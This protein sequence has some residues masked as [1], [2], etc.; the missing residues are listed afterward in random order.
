MKRSFA[1]IAATVIL[2][3]GM[4]GQAGSLG[5]VP[6]IIAKY[7]RSFIERSGAQTFGEMLDTG[8]LRYFFTGGR[9]LLVMVNGQPY[10]TTASNLDAIVLSAVER[11][12]VIRAESLGTIGGSAAVRGAFNLVLRD[13]LEGFDVRAVVRKPSRDGGESGQG[14][15]VWGEKLDAGGYITVGIDIFDRSEIEGSTRDHSRSEWTSEG[16][17][18]GSKNV[19]VGGNTAYFFDNG[20]RSSPVGGCDKAHGYTGELSNPPGITTGDK[21]C[22]FAYG[23]FW[24]DT[25]SYEQKN[26][27]INLSNP[28]GEHTE[29]EMYANFTQGKRKF[30]YA[31]SVGT[32]VLYE[33]IPKKLVNSINC[34]LGGNLGC[35]PDDPPEL[36][37]GPV[38]ENTPIALSHRFTGHGNRDWITDRDEYDIS[39]G[40]NHRIAPNIAFD[41]KFNVYRGISDIDGNTFVSIPDIVAEVTDGR[42]DVVNPLSTMPS[43]RAAVKASS[44]Q[45]DERAVSKY[46]DARFAFDGTIPG[47]GGRD[48]AWTAG[49]QFSKVDSSLQLR[50]IKDNGEIIDDVTE[51]LGS[52]G[53]S[54]AGK[55]STKVAFSEASIPVTDSVTIRAAARLD[56][57]T[58]IG[59]RRAWRFGTEYYH[60]EVVS[61]R[62]SV[63]RGDGAPSMYHLHSTKLLTHPYVSCLPA[64]EP[65]VRS[66][67]TI[68]PVQVKRELKGNPNLKPSR[69]ERRSVGFGIIKGPSYFIADWYRLTTSNLPGTNYASWAVRNYDK[70]GDGVPETRCIEGLKEGNVT[71]KD[72]FANN[73]KTDIVGLNTRFGTTVDTDWGFVGMR[74]F[75]RYVASSEREVAGV[76]RKYPLPRNAVRVVS[77][78]GRG[79]LTAYWALNYRDEIGNTWGDGR[80]KSWIGHDLTFDWKNPLGHED[81]RLT[82]GIYNVTDAKLSV[83][84]ANPTSTDG[85]RAA[86][87]GRTY[88]LTLN[89]RF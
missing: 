38:D 84:T 50:F 71:I 22:G 79:N 41:A 77:A 2:F 37:Q 40:I 16:G 18:A 58:D 17:F 45:E 27:I 23:K 33:N 46:Q 19:S 31:P 65:P 60:S 5:P 67:N 44:L 3:C 30:R 62:A 28:I 56:D 86:G 1:A 88:F 61:L 29:F 89:M 74:G 66:C 63:S 11:I 73:T 78:V 43:H 10:G 69:S 35:D 68:N 42:Y 32:F 9:N 64:D 25:P 26:A 70:C 51:V 47:I 8:I 52:G 49:I 34:N 82:A 85:P 24:W 39:A 76:K 80:F 36:D 53:T 4:H 81:L 48:I 20:L 14:S 21:G 54:Y 13:D 59:K 87:W 6:Q 12:E 75:W 57:S 7:D 83:N 15:V 55:R 72:S